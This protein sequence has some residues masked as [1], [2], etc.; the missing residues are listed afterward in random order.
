M[1][2]LNTANVS[3]GIFTGEEE[4]QLQGKYCAR[5]HTHT[6]S[7]NS[8][9]VTHSS[10]LVCGEWVKSRCYGMTNLALRDSVSS[11]QWVEKGYVV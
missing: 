11:S 6:I 4:M 7:H 3:T 5:T 2:P 10:R 9:K 8:H 1:P